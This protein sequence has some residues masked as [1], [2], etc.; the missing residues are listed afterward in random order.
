M[1]TYWFLCK[2][3]AEDNMYYNRYFAWYLRKSNNQQKL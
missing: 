1:L 3:K 2:I